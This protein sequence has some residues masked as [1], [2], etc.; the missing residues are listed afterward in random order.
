MRSP[1]NQRQKIWFV[2]GHESF[3]GFDKRLSLGKP[4]EKELAVSA[5]AGTP[6]EYAIG[7]VPDYDRYI[8][9]HE[10]EF[11]PKEGTFLYI[12]VAPE[13]DEDGN[14]V[15]GEDGNP[16]VQPDYI[17]KRVLDTQKGHVAR[18]G[19]AMR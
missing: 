3:E 4:I 10:R 2:E 8:T 1:K 14:I 19:I 17:I 18:Y 15:I 12:D 5:T 6:F 9:N 16:T 7:I 11:K 13:L